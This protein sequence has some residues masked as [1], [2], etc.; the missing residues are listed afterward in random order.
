M[1]VAIEGEAVLSQV[2]VMLTVTIPVLVY[3]IAASTLMAGLIGLEWSSLVS[4]ALKVGLLALAVA[5]AARGVSLEI[6]LLIAALA[7]AVSVVYAETG[8][9]ER[10]AAALRRIFQSN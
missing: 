3:F 7:P 4:T 10:R 9:G 8:G 5:A 6:C 1:A 2:A